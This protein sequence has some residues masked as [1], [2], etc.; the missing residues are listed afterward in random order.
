M[1]QAS[2]DMT[3]QK[4]GVNPHV[5][6]RGRM[7][8]V[9]S[10]PGSGREQRRD[11][12]QMTCEVG[13]R[14]KPPKCVGCEYKMRCSAA[15]QPLKIDNR[16]LAIARIAAVNPVFFEK[17]PPLTLCVVKYCRIASI[18]SNNQRVRR[19]C[20][21]QFQTGIA[22]LSSRRFVKRSQINTGKNCERTRNKDRRCHDRNAR[23]GD[24]RCN[25]RTSRPCESGSDRHERKLIPWMAVA[26]TDY[27][28]EQNHRR[29]PPMKKPCI[30]PTWRDEQTD[31][32]DY[33]EDRGEARCC[34]HLQD[35]PVPRQILDTNSARA[36]EMMRIKSLGN[37]MRVPV[38]RDRR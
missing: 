28:D 15:T 8:F 24:L 19:C 29:E 26:V 34:C 11:F 1:S 3:Q 35:V 10:E 25:K 17:V 16:L 21:S 7:E 27:D 4:K 33:R 5:S 6:F 2:L 22:K 18:G 38:P 36:E 30:F 23:G 20:F 31:E 37:L 13:V 12:P 14:L 32:R 9:D